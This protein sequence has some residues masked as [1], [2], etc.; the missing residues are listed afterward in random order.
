MSF[1]KRGKFFPPRRGHTGA[2]KADGDNYFAEQ[3]AAALHRSLGSTRSGVKTASAWTG[4]NEKT[5][6]NWFSGRYGPSGVHL[7]ALARHSDDVLEVFLVMSG[8]EHLLV[9]IKLESAEEAV[10]D[11]LT[12]VRRLRGGTGG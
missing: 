5:V 2:G 8:R 4:A 12:S 1:P 6:K 9:G 7:A 3:I 10:V 11:L